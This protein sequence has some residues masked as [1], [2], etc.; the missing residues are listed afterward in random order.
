MV[1]I[2]TSLKIGYIKHD[3]TQAISQL[4]A[5]FGKMSIHVF[6]PFLIGLFDFFVIKFD[7]FIYIYIS[8]SNPLS[9]KLS[10]KELMLLNCGVEEDS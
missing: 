10:A 3:F 7:E 1:L 8:D 5:F 6:F 4:C 9:R 2:C